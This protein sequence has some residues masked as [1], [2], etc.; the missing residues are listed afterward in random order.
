MDS[1]TIKWDPISCLRIVIIVLLP[2]LLQNA[3][4]AAIR[5]E[6]T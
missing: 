5:G 2:Y 6:I 4:N 3:L 1:A